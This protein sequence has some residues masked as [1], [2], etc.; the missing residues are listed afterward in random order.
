MWLLLTSVTWCSLSCPCAPQ[1]KSLSL[2]LLFWF[3]LKNLSCWGFS[4]LPQVLNN[5]SFVCRYILFSWHMDKMVHSNLFY[6]LFHSCCM[7]KKEPKTLQIDCILEDVFEH[8]TL[9]RGLSAQ[10]EENITCTFLFFLALLQDSQHCLILNDYKRTLA[11][12]SRLFALILLTWDSAMSA[13]SSASSSSCCNLRNL[14]RFTLDCSSLKINDDKD[15]QMAILQ[16]LHRICGVKM[17]FFTHSLLCC[18]LVGFHFQLQ[19][20]HQV[21]QTAQV[22]FVLFR[23]LK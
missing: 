10:E 17:L 3:F 5:Y 22:L 4:L 15:R 13:L 23:L 20:V 16:S 14:P 19:F 6:S 21:L 8:F 7:K 12:E 1:S 2:I 11:P 9:H 18:P